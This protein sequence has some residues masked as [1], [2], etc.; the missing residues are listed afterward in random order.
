MQ[1][2]QDFMN[3][4]LTNVIRSL[5]LSLGLGASAVMTSAPPV[6]AQG[7]FS[8][9]IVVNDDVVTYFELEQRALM[10]RLLRAPGD[11]VELA[12]T[13][14]IED[15]LKMQAATEAGIEIPPEDVAAGVEEFAARTNLTTEEFLKALAAEGVSAETVR[16]FVRAS[17]TWRDVV[18]SLYL[19]EA[20]PTEGEIDR[21]LGQSG[22]NGGVRVLLSEIIIPVTAQT[23]DQVQALAEEISQMTSLDRFSQ[24]ATQYSATE[25]RTNGGRMGW[26]PINELPAALRPLVLALNPGEVTAPIALPDAVALFQMRDIQETPVAAPRYSAID[27]AA[28]YIPGGRTA[29]GLAI[30]ANLATRV[31]NCDD[32]YGIAKGQPADVLLRES[33]KPSEIPRDIALELSQMDDGEISTALTRSNGQTLVFLM[34]CG[35]TAELNEDATREEIGRALATQRLSAYADSQL[36]QL[37]ADAVIIEK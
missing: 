27:Y 7:L 21:A 10:L 23:V 8:P 35:R 5:I 22:G 13:A 26:L 14:L 17:L 1:L 29:E 30:A 24:A 12:R 4:P 32:L 2:I 6:S 31:D 37:R 11:P 15:R 33:K 28:Y 16:D 36:A 20:R 25:T 9:A 18:S 3:R 34:L 19:A